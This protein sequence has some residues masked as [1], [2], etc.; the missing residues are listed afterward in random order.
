M[1]RKKKSNI[2]CNTLTKICSPDSEQ[3]EIA[4]S[5]VL[6]ATV[7]NGVSEVVTQAA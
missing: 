3:T 5:T 6:P 2:N 1:A 4:A 7:K